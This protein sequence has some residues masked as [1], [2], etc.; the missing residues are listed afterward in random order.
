[1]ATP[2]G[3][4]AT[5]KAAEAFQQTPVTLSS[6]AN[7]DAESVTKVAPNCMKIFQVYL[8]KIDEINV[9]M[10]KRV[11]EQGFTALALTCDT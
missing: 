9:D 3:E 5:F 10:F 1:M 11:R 8:S 7:S 2:L 4:V 6:W